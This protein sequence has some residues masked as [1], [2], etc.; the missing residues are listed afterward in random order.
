MWEH[1]PRLDPTPDYGQLG[2]GAD[3]KSGRQAA[4]QTGPT[5]SFAAVAI[6]VLAALVFVAANGTGARAAWEQLS[7]LLTIR[8]KPAPASPAK[9][10]GHESQKLDANSPQYQAE[11]LLERFINHYD[12]ANDQ[13]ESRVAQWRGKLQLD[14]RMNSLIQTGMNSNDLRVRAAAIEID[15][16]ALNLEKNAQTVDILAEQAQSGSQQQRVWALWSLGLL[17][18]R[19]VEQE[20]VS[21]I[22]VSHLQDPNVEVRHWSVEGLAYL[23]TDATIEPLLKTLRDDASPMVRERAACSLAQSGML[24]QQQRLSAT[25]KL[26][27]YAEDSSL[28][29]ATRAWV[30]H[31][32][33]D[34]T[35]KTLPDNPTV[36]RTALSSQR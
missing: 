35:G 3:L 21:Q 19:G 7:A 33:R 34:I 31:A 17:G 28:D 20:R 10:S 18:N 14:Q 25:P 36:W 26:V 22:L 24:S 29:T 1:D 6:G 16:A 4:A 5:K 11:L 9:L 13:I 32:L 2:P 12:G 30:Y 23:G 8:G 15:L 27:E